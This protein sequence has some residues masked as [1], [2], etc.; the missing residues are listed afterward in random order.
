MD[1]EGELGALGH[2]DLVNVLGNGNGVRWLVS[3]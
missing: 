3:K 1:V 2:G